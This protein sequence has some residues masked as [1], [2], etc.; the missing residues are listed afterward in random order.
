[1][2]HKRKYINSSVRDVV[3]SRYDGHC[4]YCGCKLDKKDMVVDHYIPVARW[5]RFGSVVDPDDV[6]NYMPSCAPCNYW[7]KA[8]SIEGFRREIKQQYKRLCNNSAVF[9]NLLNYKLVLH[10]SD[11]V[12]FYFEKHQETAEWQNKTGYMVDV[13]PFY[14]FSTPY[15]NQG[16]NNDTDH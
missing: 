4:A 1:M 15:L 2:R 6:S 16:E 13:T 11:N 12:R 14:K 8:K 7:K 5:K 9:R 10:T 3:Y